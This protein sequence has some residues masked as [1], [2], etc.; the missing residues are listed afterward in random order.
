MCR[1]WDR[2]IQRVFG[3]NASQKEL[4]EESW[5]VASAEAALCGKVCVA[6]SRSR[7]GLGCGRGGEAIKRLQRSKNSTNE[8]CVVALA[9]DRTPRGDVN[10]RDRD[11]NRDLMQNVLR[12]TATN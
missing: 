1:S 4:R 11:G 7:V 2:A 12:V 6:A 3:V 9:W 10:D 8:S 5:V